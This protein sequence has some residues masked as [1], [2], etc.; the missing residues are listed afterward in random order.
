MIPYF[1][2]FTVKP[3]FSGH[4]KV[5][6]TRVWMTNGSLMKGQKYCRMLHESIL[7]YFWPALRDIQSSNPIL[8]FFLIGRSKRGLTVCY[9]ANRAKFE[10]PPIYLVFCSSHFCILISVDCI[11]FLWTVFDR[12]WVSTLVRPHTFVFIILYLLQIQKRAVD[13]YWLVYEYTN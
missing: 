5:D 1:D 3:V 2:D 7:H 4:S 12:L 13:S 8:V 10:Y 6:K 9:I 11:W